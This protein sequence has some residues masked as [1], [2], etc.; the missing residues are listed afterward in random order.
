MIKERYKGIYYGW[1]IV[2]LAALGS[3]FSGP[4]Q[5]YSNSIFIDEYIHTFGWSRSEISGIYSAATLAAG[6]LM[7]VVGRY[8][9][10]FGQRQMMVVV[11]IILGVA[12]FFNS[13]VQ[14]IWMLGIGFF[15]VRLFGQ[16][17]MSLIPN[18]LV[19]QWFI[20]KRGRAMSFMAMGGFASAAFF[21][22]ANAWLIDLWGWEA[23]WRVWGI[24]LLV[25]F[26]PLAF[27]GVRNRP[28]DMGLLPDGDRAIPLKAEEAPDSKQKLQKPVKDDDWTLQE[29]MKTRAFWAILICV[30]IPALVNTGITFHL[31][32]IFGESQL[33]PQLAATVLSMMAVI[34]FPISLAAGFILEKVRTTLLLTVVFVIEIAVLILLIYTHSVLAGVVFGTIWGIGNGLERITLNIIWPNYFG[35]RYIGSINGIAMMIMVIG[36]AF[37]PLPLGIGFDHFHSYKESLF[38]LLVFPIIGV[39]ASLL[40]KQPIKEI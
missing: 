21:P 29:A 35:R 13:I 30:G 22:I 37:G 31:L 34:G 8:V 4:G 3:F 14:N 40:A 15:L 12:C 18:T 27:F 2:C 23:A 26:A 28:E 32:S 36:S 20:K 24:L 10:K 16:G 9:D 11:S 17:S 19:P 25:L 33:S 5:T 7:M 1:I 39:I 38:L 6:L